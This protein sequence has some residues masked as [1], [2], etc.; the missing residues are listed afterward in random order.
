MHGMSQLPT[1]L[2]CCNSGWADGHCVLSTLLGANALFSAYLGYLAFP[3]NGYPTN[4]NAYT[5]ASLPVLN[6]AV[7]L[8]LRAGTGCAVL[9]GSLLYVC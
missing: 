7:V 2:Q 6:P 5:H 3:C 1:A 9:R 4:D 8:V